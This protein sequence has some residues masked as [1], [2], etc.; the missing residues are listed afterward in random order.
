MML[1]SAL[2][3]WDSPRRTTR[4]A[5]RFSVVALRVLMPHIR[6]STQGVVTS[7]H[8]VNWCRYKAPL[9]CFFSAPGGL[10]AKAN[11]PSRSLFEAAFD[12]LGIAQFSPPSY[13]MYRHSYLFFLPLLRAAASAR[14]PL[15]SAAPKITTQRT[16]PALPWFDWLLECFMSGR[17]RGQGFV[18]QRPRV[19]VLRSPPQG[20]RRPGLAG[21][22]EDVG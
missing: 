21:E 8:G 15:V 14:F 1:M 17:C 3:R 9:L 22:K 12:Q 16:P 4:P 2:C 19:P 7:T 20:E 10:T 5:A 11:T 13:A 6:R 18:G